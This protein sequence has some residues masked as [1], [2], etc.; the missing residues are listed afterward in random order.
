MID[1]IRNTG[2]RKV[3][4]AI[5]AS[6]LTTIAALGVIFF[7]PEQLRLNLMDFSLVIIINLSVSFAVALFLIPALM[8]RMKIKNLKGK[9]YYKDKRRIVKLTGTYEKGIVF[10]K[11]LKWIY[12]VVLILGFGIPFHWLPDKVGGDDQ[13]S[14]IYNKTFGSAWFKDDLKPSLEKI[15]GGSLRLFAVNVFENSYYAEPGKTMLHVNGR[16]PEGCTIQQMNEAI[17]QMENFISQFEEVELFQT[18]VSSY[19][20]S[21]VTIHFKPEH[22]WS[23]FPLLLKS[24]LESKAI[25]LGGADWQVYGVGIGFSNAIYDGYKSNRIVLEGYNYEQLYQYAELLKKDMLK[26]PRI[27]GVDILG[28]NLWD[29]NPIHEFFMVFNE[30]QLA[31]NSVSPMDFYGS[32]KDKSYQTEI[33]PVYTEQEIYRVYI[34]SDTYESFN[35]W[36]L[37]HS[38]LK[39]EENLFK[40]SRFGSVEKRKSGNDIYKYDQQ[41]R[42]VVAFDFIGP[43]MLG[44][45]VERKIIEAFK[46]ILSFG[47]SIQSDQNGYMVRPSEEKKWNKED[48]GQYYLIFLVIVAIY[49]ICAILLESLLQPLAI[50]AMI[51]ISFI[52]IFLTFFVF[53][54]NFDQGG[55]ASFILLSGLVVNAALYI[56]ND[57]NNYKTGNGRAKLKRYLRAYNHKIIPVVLTILSTVLSLTPLIVEGQKEIFWFA[58][59]AGTI[60]GLVFSLIAILIYLPLFLKISDKTILLPEVRSDLKLG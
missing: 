19:R 40:M 12:I 55:F 43:S 28:S 5:F 22:E 52:G 26:N 6:S 50:I 30:E 44:Q 29:E 7:F 20:T 58:F 60:G 37:N 57:Y 21:N 33:N 36:D 13:W 8:D 27:A 23:G 11:R 14:K 45:K 1:H 34:T 32:L 16:M 17:R 9:R 56:V 18:S 10:S 24:K 15:L 4:L 47:Y 49:F 46:S 31:L 59:A 54:L 39:A 48:K 42:L 38:P 3:L 25:D 2:N 51:P 41:Y 35:V 53:D